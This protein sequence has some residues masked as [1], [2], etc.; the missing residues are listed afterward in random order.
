MKRSLTL[1]AI[2]PMILSACGLTRIVTV[3]PDYGS[4]TTYSTVVT[5]PRTHTTTTTTRVYA[6]D[7][8]ISL[9]LDLQAVGAAFAQSNTVQEFESLL[10]NASYMLSNL[11]LNG[12]GYVDYLRV[13][14][15]LEGRTH[16]FLIQAVL[17]H[18]IYQ[19]VATLVAELPSIQTACVQIIGSPY[20]YGPNYIIQPVYY[21]RPLIYTHLMRV[22]YTVWRSPWHWDYFPTYYR[23]PA[24]ILLSH[25]HA[26]IDT[27][28]TNHRYC[29]HFDY[30]RTCH[31]PDYDR[32]SRPNQRN[33]YG[34][35]HPERAFNVRNETL[36][37]TPSAQS[38]GRALNALDIREQ[39]DASTVKSTSQN[40]Q[41]A[42]ETT[43]RGASISSNGPARNASTV[44]GTSTSTSTATPARNATTGSSTTTSRSAATSGSGSTTS[45][46]AATSGSSTTTSRSAAT[47]GSS[48]TARSAASSSSTSR[49]AA[50]AKQPEAGQT[51][52]R[53]RVNNSGSTN[54]RTT[55]V[56]ESGQKST[57]RRGST[58]SSSASST[59]RSSAAT[60]SSR[61]AGSTATRSGAT[62]TRSS[63]SSTSGTTATRS[64]SAS[65]S[66]RSGSGSSTARGASTGR[67]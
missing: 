5:V 52:V 16:V 23:H 47:A 58:S 18:N 48:S 45:R 1:L 12:D 24:P 33:D 10:N 2:L 54:T 56:S 55:S 3:S 20:L 8:D 36:V 37:A 21:T 19:D 40:R 66:S 27:F 9:Y 46:S 64:S 11:D 34:S 59:S 6:A 35:Q 65:S 63:S 62:A 53:S 32:V 7:N 30:A 67:R 44:N 61:S 43:A 22:G 38:S 28:M 25:Y 31:Y 42:G 50:T 4:R 41:P 17:G 29:H 51:M 26:Y 13:L 49:S 15:T 39:L 60:T 14:E 57:V